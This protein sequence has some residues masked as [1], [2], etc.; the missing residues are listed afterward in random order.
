MGRKG[1]NCDA[2]SATLH[3]QAD[4]KRIRP[5]PSPCRPVYPGPS[6]ATSHSLPPTPF[7]SFS[8]FPRRRN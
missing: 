2:A 3:E 4:W 7:F 5:F 8:F 6:G 1:L